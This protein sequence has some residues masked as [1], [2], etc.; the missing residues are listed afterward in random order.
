[1]SDMGKFAAGKFMLLGAAASVLLW[2]VPFTEAAAASAVSPAISAAVADT[3][4][5]DADKNDDAD[6]KPAES[7]AFAGVKPGEKIADLLP[8]RGYF[9]R[10]FSKVAGPKGHVYA[11]L[12]DASRAAAVTAIA[13][14]PAYANVTVVTQPL[15]EFH[16]AE[17]LDLVW[18]SRN[19]H[20]IHNFPN[21]DATMAAFN[22]AVF[23]AL[24]PGGTYIVLDH[25]AEAGSGA[26]DTSTLHRIDPAVVK[27]EVEAAGFKLVAESKLLHN[28]DDAHTA[29]VFDGS[30]KGK[31]DQF[32]L[33]FRKPAE[34]H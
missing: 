24:K 16:P 29:K 12:P 5:P 18:T 10:I 4:R 3:A 14:D 27:K 32:I 1:M 20:D 9:T 6:R 2:A 15:T 7:L 34:K 21:A 31:T 8:G 22:K 11:V 30:V 19:Y 26:R 17:P 25:A 33:K 13:A 28:P 23:E